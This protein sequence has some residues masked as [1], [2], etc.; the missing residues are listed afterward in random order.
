[1]NY[2]EDHEKKALDALAAD[3][4]L[5]DGANLDTVVVD[6][7]EYDARLFD[8]TASCEWF[9]RIVL[10]LPIDDENLEAF[11]VRICDAMNAARTTRDFAV[12]LKLVIEPL[13]NALQTIERKDD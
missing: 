10:G 3:M 7:S 12:A 6:R 5:H 2:H 1:M 9:R 11:A 4:G 8:M 13:Y